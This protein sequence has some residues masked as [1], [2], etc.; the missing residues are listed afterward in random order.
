M[1]IMDTD[2]RFLDRYDAL[3]TPIARAVAERAVDL[4][5]Y[6]PEEL[7][8]IAHRSFIAAALREAETIYEREQESL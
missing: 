4:L 1:V 7:Q 5:I 3:L 8:N 6:T 2:A